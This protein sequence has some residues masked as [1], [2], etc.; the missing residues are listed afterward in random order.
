MDAINRLASKC[1]SRHLLWLLHTCFI[2]SECVNISHPSEVLVCISV[3]SERVFSSWSWWV[4]SGLFCSFPFGVVWLRMAETQCST[5]TCKKLFQ[6]NLKNRSCREKDRLEQE[7]LFMTLFSGFE[8][9][10]HQQQVDHV[11]T[12]ELLVDSWSSCVQQGSYQSDSMQSSIA[13]RLL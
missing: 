5:W 8:R 6:E 9:D 13:K 1:I 10:G 2:S 11:Q 12:A 7:I 3:G 4:W